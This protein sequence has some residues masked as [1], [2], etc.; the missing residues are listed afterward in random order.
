MVNGQ[1][2]GATKGAARLRIDALTI[3]VAVLDWSA[4]SARVE[5]PKMDLAGPMKAELEVFRSDGA[6]ASSTPIIVTPV[7]AVA[8]RLAIAK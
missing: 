6:I 2:L 1:P 3:P 7:A 4:T 8:E 5:L